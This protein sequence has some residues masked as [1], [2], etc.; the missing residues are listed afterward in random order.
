MDVNMDDVYN[1]ESRPNLEGMEMTSKKRLTDVEW[2]PFFGI[3]GGDG[4]T[5]GINLERA[6]LAF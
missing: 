3:R 2:I 1:R 5:P 4:G 6:C